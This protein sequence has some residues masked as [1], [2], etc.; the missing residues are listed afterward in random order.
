MVRILLSR[1]RHQYYVLSLNK[2]YYRRVQLYQVDCMLQIQEAR[3]LGIKGD[4]QSK[5]Q[6]V[7]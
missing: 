3:K 7:N 4:A 6:T 5:I 1:F 2:H